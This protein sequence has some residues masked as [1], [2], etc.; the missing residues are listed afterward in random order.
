M[1]HQSESFNKRSRLIVAPAVDGAPRRP[2]APLQANTLKTRLL[3]ALRIQQDFYPCFDWVFPPPVFPK[4]APPADAAALFAQRSVMPGTYSLYLH[5]PFCKTLCS[6][7][8][9]HVLPGGSDDEKAT[10]VGYMLR[11]MA[12]YRQAL[13]GQRCESI[14]IGGGTPTSLDDATLARL[15]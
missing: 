14:Y 3:D 5:I 2:L 8:Y 10:Y 1:K 9:F 15:F 12:L 7:C 4:A 11:E 13:R 6:F